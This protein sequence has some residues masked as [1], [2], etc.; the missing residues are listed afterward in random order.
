[1]PINTSW[2]T[3]SYDQPMINS[4][5]FCWYVFAIPARRR[6][7]ADHYVICDYLQMRDRVLAFAAPRGNDHRDHKLWRC[8]LRLYPDERTGY[9]RWEMSPPAATTSPAASSTQTTPGPSAC[10]FRRA[11]ISA[12]SGLAASPPRTGC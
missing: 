7:Q 8:D 10:R 3:G 6:Y 5:P 1:V 11:S 12:G 9:F 2:F 4:T